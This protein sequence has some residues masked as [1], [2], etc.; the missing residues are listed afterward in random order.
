MFAIYGTTHTKMY[1]CTYHNFVHE[2]PN[3]AK[4]SESLS[5]VVPFMAHS[6]IVYFGYN[7][8][9]IIATNI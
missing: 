3:M 6:V 8:P 1:V 5:N 9:T 7:L 4:L 2:V